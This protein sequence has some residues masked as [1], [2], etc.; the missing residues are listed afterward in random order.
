MNT[1]DVLVGLNYD[2]F[3]VQARD[4]DEAIEKVMELLNDSELCPFGFSVAEIAAST[5]K[6]AL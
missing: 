4:P 3:T 2:K 1:Y 6:Q 5:E